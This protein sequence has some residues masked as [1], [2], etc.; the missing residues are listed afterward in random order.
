MFVDA[1]TLPEDTVIDSEV[2]IIGTGP[3]GT[4]LAHELRSQN[5]RVCLLESGGTELDEATQSLS[6]G[7]I[8]EEIKQKLDR[9]RCRQFGG[10][11]NLWRDRTG[12]NHYSVRLLPLDKIDF[13]RRDWLP[14][15]GWSFDKSHLDPFYERAQHLCRLRPF[16]YHA[17]DWED[18]RTPR[19]PLAEGRLE[20]TMYQFGPRNVFTHELKSEIARSPNITTYLNANVVEIETNDTAKAITR[21]RVACLSG[22]QFWVAAK[23]FVLA[24]GGIENARLLLLS[25]KAQKAGLGN[26]NDLV[27]RF[28][29]EHPI[30]QIG[31]FR[32]KDRQL[33]NSTA[34][35]DLRWANNILVMGKLSLTDA[36]MRQQQ[37][38]NTSL[39]LVPRSLAYESPAVKSLK[40]FLSS[41]RQGKVPQARSHL[42]AA[43]NGIDEIKS[44]IY[45]RTF[46]IEETPYS[47]SEGGWSYF[48]NNEKRFGAFE[49]WA[50]TEQI[51]NP[52]IRVTLG[53]E[54]DR[55]GLRRIQHIRWHSSELEIQSNLQVEEILREE[56]AQADLGQ[57]QSW[58]ELTGRTKPKYYGGMHHM[59]TTRMHV[60]PKQGVVD[61]NCCIHGIANLY[62]AGSS[63][64]PTGGAA[65]PT[66]TIVAL[67]MRLADRIKQAIELDAIAIGNEQLL[68][69]Q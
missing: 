41:I 1:R 27:G 17:E 36:V 48:Q 66:L 57:F 6:Q 29:M 22:N 42:Q 19:L 49:V 44:H 7:R 39:I 67:A 14:Y 15:S 47:I 60:D 2:C 16:A 37:L 65:N 53:E 10:T 13:E 55:L 58:R 31:V 68:H 32:P 5:F 24:T 30:F 8:V 62:V 3:A 69:V 52:D 11:A 23:I 9:S 38:L 59:G 64:F 25:N 46:K 43:I 26:Q 50:A 51:P 18:D 40:T 54:R 4:T 28:F 56:I 61:E 33:F 45:R 63:V 20:T 21:V 35:Y 34:L 12:E